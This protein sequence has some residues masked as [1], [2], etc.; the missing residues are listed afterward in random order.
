MKMYLELALTISAGIGFVY[1]LFRFFRKDSA[2][3]D[4]GTYLRMIVF[5]LGCAMLGRLYGTLMLLVKGEYYPGFDVGMLGIIGS[6][7]FFFSAN[8]GQVDSVVDDGSKSCIKARMIALIAPLYVAAL[9]CG[10]FAEYGVNEL[11]ISVGV[12]ALALAL[13]S[14]FHLKHLIM[15]DTGSGIL[16]SMRAYNLLALVYA[17][18]CLSEVLVDGSSLPPAVPIILC[19]VECIVLLAFLPVLERGV[20]KWTT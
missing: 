17:V 8:F 15:K 2:S 4:S 10:V 12:E 18:L 11:T 13:A 6:F 5:G 16:K 3:S 9:W 19:V 1:G 7:L 14:Y 20:K